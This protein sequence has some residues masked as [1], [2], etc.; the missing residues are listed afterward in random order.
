MRWQQR[1]NVCKRRFTCNWFCMSIDL[2]RRPCDYHKKSIRHTMSAISDL[3]TTLIGT[4][5]FDDCSLSQIWA[6]LNCA[7]TEFLRHFSES[8]TEIRICRILLLLLQSCTGC[9]HQSEVNGNEKKSLF[10]L[11]VVNGLT[12]IPHIFSLLTIQATFTY[13]Q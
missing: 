10:C 4:Y 7:C 6:E 5:L 2:M 13:S 8:L 1:I 12:S 11:Y 9:A 3:Y